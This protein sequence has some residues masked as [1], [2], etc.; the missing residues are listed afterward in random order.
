MVHNVPPRH[1]GSG[2]RL[3]QLGPLEPR[4]VVIHPDCPLIIVRDVA[5]GTPRIG[6]AGPK[7]HHGVD[8]LAEPFRI[9]VT[10]RRDETPA[11]RSHV[12]VEDH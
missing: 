12:S 9:R 5:G 4:R 10:A 8:L 3:Q 2:Q 11:P 7:D 1:R 6:P